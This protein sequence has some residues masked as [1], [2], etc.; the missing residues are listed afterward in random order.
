MK[1]LPGRLKKKILLEE[2]IVPFFREKPL[3]LIEDIPVFYLSRFV[4][5]P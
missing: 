3:G 1:Y 5:K 2:G 4:E